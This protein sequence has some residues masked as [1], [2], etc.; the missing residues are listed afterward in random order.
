MLNDLVH[1]LYE[2]GLYE[3]KCLHLE[4]TQ[5]QNQLNV[6]LQVFVKM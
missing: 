1:A 3:K 4:F 6:T 5:P 2:D